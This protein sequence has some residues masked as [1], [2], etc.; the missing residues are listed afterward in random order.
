MGTKA[1][2]YVQSGDVSVGKQTTE[3][4]RYAMAHGWSFAI[5]PAG[6]LREAV[7]LIREGQATLLLLA[8]GDEHLS[9]IVQAVE[10]AGGSVEVCHPGHAGRAPAGQVPDA[11]VIRMAEHGGTPEEIVRLLGVAEDRVRRILD[12]TRRRR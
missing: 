6:A 12:R 10:E 4:L 7:R 9:E 3:C 11:M 8:Y 1:L 5:V 2:I